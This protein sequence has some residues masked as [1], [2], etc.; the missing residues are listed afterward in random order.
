VL[1][2]AKIVCHYRGLLLRSARFS[3]IH[4]PGGIIASNFKVVFLLV[5]LYNA[6]EIQRDAGKGTAE[7][8][9]NATKVT[10]ESGAESGNLFGYTLI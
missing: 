8:A 3:E 2:C 9:L 10:S 6:F 4:I 5:G 1:I 7:A